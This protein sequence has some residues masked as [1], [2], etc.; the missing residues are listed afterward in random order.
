VAADSLAV[1]VE[2]KNLRNQMSKQSRE[3]EFGNVIGLL[4]AVVDIAAASVSQRIFIFSA[5][6]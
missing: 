4:D 1:I 3:N 2:T 6:F 5:G